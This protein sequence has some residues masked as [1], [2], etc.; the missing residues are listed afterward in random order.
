MIF[1]KFHSIFSAMSSCERVTQFINLLA[2]G[3]TS[4]AFQLLFSMPGN[5]HSLLAKRDNIA[6]HIYR[7]WIP[8]TIACQTGMVGMPLIS[9]TTLANNIP[10]SSTILTPLHHQLHGSSGQDKNTCI[11]MNGMTLIRSV[12]T[13][14]LVCTET[15]PFENEHKHTNLMILCETHCELVSFLRVLF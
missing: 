4:S 5:Y 8:S 14:M 6:K 1:A 2:D 15:L 10:Q 7:I 3:L 11:N 13:F 9:A 12:F